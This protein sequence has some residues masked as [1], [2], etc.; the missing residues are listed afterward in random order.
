MQEIPIL[1]AG[2]Q[3]G[4]KYWNSSWQLHESAAFINKEELC[5]CVH[6]CLLLGT[7]E[8][9]NLTTYERIGVDRVSIAVFLS[10]PEAT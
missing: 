8:W 4:A 9:N 2:F 5:T 7:L 1:V 6:F 10:L 3:M